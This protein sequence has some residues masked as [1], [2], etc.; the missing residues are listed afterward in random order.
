MKLTGC[1]REGAGLG[2]Q[3]RSAGHRGGCTETASGNLGREE[4]GFVVVDFLSDPPEFA[5]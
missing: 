4:S 3:R 5:I 1:R 2:L